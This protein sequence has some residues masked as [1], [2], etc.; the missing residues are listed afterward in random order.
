M[1]SRLQYLRTCRGR[2]RCTQRSKSCVRPWYV[3]SI[4]DKSHQIT[5]ARYLNNKSAFRNES[6]SR[7][8]LISNHM[9][10]LISI[11]Q[12]LRKGFVC[13]QPDSRCR[14]KSRSPIATLGTSPNLHRVAADLK[15][16]AV[17]SDLEEKL[18]LTAPL[19]SYRFGTLMRRLIYR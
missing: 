10:R 5:S 3:L 13:C 9:S 17:I 18:F 7:C 2:E 8:P 19:P 16:A 14:E 11:G 1:I 4:H 12:H 15:V 6:T